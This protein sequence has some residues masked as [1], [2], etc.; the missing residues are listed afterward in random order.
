ME[1]IP[2]AQPGHAAT[3][4]CENCKA[5]NAPTV[6]FCTR[7]GFPI[8]GTEEEKKIFYGRLK[9][10][11]I[12]LEECQD[13]IRSARNTLYVLAGLMVLGGIAM[14]FLDK[15]QGLVLLVTY[16]ILA[17]IFVGLGFWSLKKPFAAIISALVIYLTLQLIGAFADPKSLYQ[18]II[19]KVFVIIFLFKGLKSA[20]DAEALQKELNNQ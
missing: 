17:A 10:K 14:Y 8:N 1:P 18:G 11:Q 16:L 3:F 5:E 9:V 15:A 20:K 7:C 4:A 2:S 13:K 12:S 6:K 19:I